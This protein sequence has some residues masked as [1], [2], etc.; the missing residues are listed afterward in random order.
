MKALQSDM[1]NQQAASKFIS[2]ADQAYDQGNALN[3]WMAIIELYKLL[4]EQQDEI[5]QNEDL[6]PGIMRF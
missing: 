6:L 2:E 3:L 4:P 5:K 1:V